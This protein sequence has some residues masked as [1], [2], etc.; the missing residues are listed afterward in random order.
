[1]LKIPLPRLDS[2]SFPSDCRSAKQ[3]ELC[4]SSIIQS[5]ADRLKCNQ[6]PHG[7]A[8]VFHLNVTR[9]RACRSR[10]RRPSSS[11]WSFLAR[12]AA[13][14]CAQCEDNLCFKPTDMPRARTECHSRHTMPRAAI[15]PPAPSSY[16]ELRLVN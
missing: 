7:I 16:R 1:M 9:A 10:P 8:P 4:R 11:R 15:F 6:D 14:A 13:A 12:T 5:P 3:H 2:L